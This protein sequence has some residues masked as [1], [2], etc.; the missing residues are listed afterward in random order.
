M[1]Y[2]SAH[3]CIRSNTE[4]HVFLSHREL[5]ACDKGWML[6]VFRRV[7][8][9]FSVGIILITE[10]IHQY[11]RVAV[12]EKHSR[13]RV[14]RT[15]RLFRMPLRAVRLAPNE[16]HLS[17]S[18]QR[19]VCRTCPQDLRILLVPDHNVDLHAS[20]KPFPDVRMY[21]W[22]SAISCRTCSSRSCIFI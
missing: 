12:S 7:L 21:F 8:D 19:L 6:L 11:R 5:E 10:G 14:Q 18:L 9:S 3:N 13:S 1:I 20:N 4:G 17:R 16:N 22:A 2:C 15:H